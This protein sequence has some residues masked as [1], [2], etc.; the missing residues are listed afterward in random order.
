MDKRDNKI[1]VFNR[2]IKINVATVLIFAIL[3]YV[4]ISVFVASRK[5]PITT[6][7]VNKSSIDNNIQLEGLAIRDEQIIMS[8]KTGYICYY[9][10]DGE[11]VKNNST[12]CTIDETG[13]VY[14]TINNTETMENI[15]KTEDYEDIRSLISLYKVGY[16]DV[17]FYSAYH[18]QIDV[19]N[20]VLELSN[21]VL[22]QEI[23]NGDNKRAVLS[24][25]SAP[26]SGL[27]TYYTDG[28]ESFD[29]NSVSAKDFDKSEYNKQTLKTGDIVSA[30][31]PIVKIIPSEEWNIIAPVT[32]EQI[33]KLS[34]KT[35]ISFSINNSSYKII[36][37]FEIFTGSDG[38]YINI[39]ID[40]Y[41]SNFISERYLSIEI[42]MEE[43]SGLKIPV[44]SIVEKE[45][46]KVP[47]SFFSGGGNQSGTNRLNLQ[48]KSDDGELT[49]KQIAPTIY[50]TDG[51]YCLIDPSSL[52]ASD[53][54][55]NIDTN[56]TL[57][58]SVLETTKL[59]G[60]YSANRGTAEFKVVNIIKTIDE[61]ALIESDGTLKIYDNIILDSSSVKENQIIY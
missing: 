6:Y 38:S 9:I 35:K 50:E 16:K 42:F 2:D 45:V 24:A 15:L 43:E 21:E 12:V 30:N 8:D 44:S 51:E 53:V 39:K 40:K 5:D 61:F 3:I 17:N 41:L 52:E 60:V 1:V 34:E 57:A 47:V 25:V 10:R 22:M 13:Q 4:L 27:V 46:Y 36:M 7:K 37:P 26:Y 54:L 18:F 20:K 11:K 49:I 32:A 28:F 56:E 48:A 29:I 33:S 23:K 58:V 14:D 59:E 31:N 55:Y 19:N